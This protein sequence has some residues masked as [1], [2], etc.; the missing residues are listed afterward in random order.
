MSRVFRVAVLVV[1]LGATAVPAAPATALPDAPSLTGGAVLAVEEAEEPPGPEPSGPNA[2]GNPAAPQDYEANFL[3][4]AATGLLAL[5][6]LGLLGL[7]GLYYAL[8]I[9]PRRHVQDE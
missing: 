8:V 2:S 7:G 3:W 9:R 4:G 6:V 1:L 5:S